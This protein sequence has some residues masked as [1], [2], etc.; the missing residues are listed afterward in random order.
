[1]T[2]SLKIKNNHYYAVINYKDEGRYRQKWFP[3]GL[4]V[5]GNKRKAESMLDEIKR[6]FEEA[7]STPRGDMKFTTYLQQ[8][9][10]K[11]KPM[12][13]LSTWEGYESYILR[14]IIPFFEPL[15]LSL[16]ELKPQHIK[17]Y[18]DAKYTGGRLDGKAGGLTVRSIKKH[19][20]VIKEAL[21]DAVFDELIKTNP[22]TGVL[23]PAKE[24][25]KTEERFLTED[26]ANEVLK[27][28]AGHPLEPLV[29]ITLYYGLR[30]SEILGL[31]WSAIDFENNTMSINH[32]VVKNRTI[33][34]KDK[35]KSESSFHTY[36][37]IDD[38]K[39][40]LLKRKEEQERDKEEVGEFYKD[41]DYVFTWK[42]GTLFRPDY[43]TRGF[44]RV[45]IRNK[46]PVM[47]FHDLRHSTA[48]ILYDK[49][50]DIKD[51]QSWLRHADSSTTAGIYIH[52][53]ENR[54]SAIA[55]SLNSTFKLS[56]GSPLS[57]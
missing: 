15:S 23:M 48:S 56:D 24:I 11:K 34:A 9:L 40:V 35:T 49:G 6:E 52:I 33:V 32:T 4:E 53:S 18:Y 47:R 8:W 10:E 57:H 26:E 2:G 30:R 41:N 44:E 21:R 1:M 20:I 29:Y 13:E 36:H 45:L 31:R 43:V 19:A 50:W 7:Y 3:L 37:L 16:R 28:F 54:K 38:V 51:I 14:H 27:A 55:D 17:A 42:D 39:S 25:R 5:K 22:A 46:I 12:I